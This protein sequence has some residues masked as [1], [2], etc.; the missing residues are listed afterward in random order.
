VTVVGVGFSTPETNASWA[1]RMGYSYALWSD[2]ERVLAEHYGAVTEWDPD[3]P[4]RHA[5]ILDADGRARVRHDGG[6]S[7]GADPEAVLEDCT[8]LFGAAP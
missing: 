4:L 5:F 3:A 8:A 2:A 7:L 6:V 1:E